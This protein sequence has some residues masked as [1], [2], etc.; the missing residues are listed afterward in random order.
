M[1]GNIIWDS[2][3]TLD[4]NMSDGSV[5]TG[6]FLQDEVNAGDGGNGYANV[7]IDASSKWIV[8]GDSTVSKLTSSGKIQDKDGNTVTVQKADGTVLSKGSSR[9][10]ITVLSSFSAGNAQDIADSS[11]N[12]GDNGNIGKNSSVKKISK[13][14]KVGKTIKVKVGSNVKVIKVSNKKCVKASI[15]G[16]FVV[17]KGKKAG[18]SIVSVKRNNTIRKITV[19]VK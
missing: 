3:S 5:L 19:K 4:F 8:T 1:Q 2:I 18:K 12:K 16:D 10:K 6:A 14:V 11:E 17:I 13:A 9:Y 7:A 15:K